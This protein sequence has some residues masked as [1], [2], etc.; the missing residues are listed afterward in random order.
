VIDI[1]VRSL[2]LLD[3]T[4]GWEVSSEPSLS[5]HRHILFILWDLVPVRLI[6]NPRGTNWRSF[7]EDLKEQLERGPGMDMKS[8]VGLGLAV[9]WVQQALVLTYEDNCPLKPIKVGRQTLKWST[10]LESLRKE[11]RRIVNKCQ[12]YKNPHSWDLFRE[13]QRTYRKEVRKAS[14]SA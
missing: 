6:R 1:T 4:I 13:A 8:E 10:E 14:K 5:D 9:H 3:S 12:S 11:V 7:R 2:G